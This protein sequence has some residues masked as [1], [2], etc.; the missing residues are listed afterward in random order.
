[1]LLS[2]LAL[3][4]EQGWFLLISDAARAAGNEAIALPVAILI[5]AALLVW[6]AD[7]GVKRGWLS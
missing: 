3:L 5:I 4:A 2:F 6:L 1:M 7:K